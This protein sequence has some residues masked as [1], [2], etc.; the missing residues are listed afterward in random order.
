[1]EEISCAPVDIQINEGNVSNHLDNLFGLLN[2]EDLGKQE[3]KKNFGSRSEAQ[4]RD[5]NSKNGGNSRN[6]GNYEVGTY[7]VTLCM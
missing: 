3:T 2:R 5:C 4:K 1:M 7:L 6:M